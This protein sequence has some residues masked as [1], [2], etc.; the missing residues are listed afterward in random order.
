MLNFPSIKIFDSSFIALP[1]RAV[2]W[3]EEETLLVSDTHFGKSAAFRATGIP[4]PEGNTRDDLKRLSDALQLTQ[5]KKVTFLGDLI[6]H[7]ASKTPEVLALLR[8][9]FNSNK[10]VEFTLLMG[11]HDV[12][13]DGIPEIPQIKVFQELIVRDKFLLKHYPEPREGYYVLCGHL[14]PGITLKGR[15]RE[16]LRLG[17]SLFSKKMA[18]LQ[19]FGSFTGNAKAEIQAGDTVFMAHDG[20]VFTVK[21]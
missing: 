12:S 1:Q 14:H 20:E 15:G 3:L 6:H 13:S 19:A 8:D 5:A 7:R 11:N 16:R 10:D 18:V 21:F 4:I 2:Y 9:W 17:C